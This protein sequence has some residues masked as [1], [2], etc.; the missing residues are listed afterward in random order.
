M[1]C[2]SFCVPKVE[3]LQKLCQ[4]YTLLVNVAS[5]YGRPSRKAVGF[6]GQTLLR[7]SFS[8]TNYEKKSAAS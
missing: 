5:R 4:T 1:F 6:N 8:K 2:A 7:V 3:N